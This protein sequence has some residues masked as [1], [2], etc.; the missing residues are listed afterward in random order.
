MG[1]G[2]DFTPVLTPSGI[3]DVTKTFE[4]ATE[5]LK[6]CVSKDELTQ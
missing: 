4:A 1:F 5:D 2:F 6:A 3:N